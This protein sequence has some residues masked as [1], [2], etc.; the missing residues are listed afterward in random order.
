MAAAHSARRPF[1]RIREKAK[2]HRSSHVPGAIQL[3]LGRQ[4]LGMV[5][6]SVEQCGGQL[7]VGEHLHPPAEG[8]VRPATVER[9]S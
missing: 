2:G 8:E 7:L 4:H 9:R 6:E 5:A 1:S 3:L